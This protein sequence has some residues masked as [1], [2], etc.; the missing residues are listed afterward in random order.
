[1]K[2][3]V[4]KRIRF[5]LCVCFVCGRVVSKGLHTHTCTQSHRFFCVELSLYVCHIM[6]VTITYE[7]CM[8]SFCLVFLHSVQIFPSTRWSCSFTSGAVPLLPSLPVDVADSSLTKAANGS[9]A[10]EQKDGYDPSLYHSFFSDPVLLCN[11]KQ[12][13]SHIWWFSSLI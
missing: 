5:S 7:G 3:G 2:E 10:E 6:A 12:H 4:K 9:A 1:M 8:V 13:E 11:W